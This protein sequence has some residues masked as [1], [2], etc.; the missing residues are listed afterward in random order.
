MGA[1]VMLKPK[2]KTVEEYLTA[3]RAES[4]KAAESTLNTSRLLN[5]AEST[6]GKDFEKLQDELEDR[7]DR[8]SI[9]RLKQLCQKEW[10]VA[11]VG[12]IP[13]SWRTLYELKQCTDEILDRALE[14]DIIRPD[15]TRATAEQLHRKTD[16]PDNDNDDD[17]SGDGK[18]EKKKR[19]PKP[20]KPITELGHAKEKLELREKAV[21]YF[22]FVGRDPAE[23]P[24]LPLTIQAVL[25]KRAARD[26]WYT[27]LDIIAM[28]RT[29][30]G[31]IDCD[32]ATCALAQK[33]VDAK[34]YYTKEDNGLEHAWRGNI[35]LNPPFSHP[36]PWIDTL[37]LELEE[38]RAK[39]A[40]LLT[41]DCSDTSWF[42]KAKA[43]SN[44]I[45]F[46]KGRIAFEKPDGKGGVKSVGGNER[47]NFIFYFGPEAEAFKTEFSKLGRVEIAA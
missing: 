25:D 17:D 43:K 29:V 38:K 16:K 4:L 33:T 19:L 7:Y 23:V 42:H 35:W 46:I 41:L 24:P 20:P 32:P 22:V 11:H 12:N 26:E 37:L 28:A 8:T 14:A 27:P 9:Y 18:P 3:I 47:G 39:Q 5:Q 40:I 15:M 2:L 13:S 31:T 45:C 34:K 44:A 6:L 21:E 10:L 1:R 36:A 30:M